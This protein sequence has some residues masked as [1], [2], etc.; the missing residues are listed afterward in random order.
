MQ[1]MDFER[2]FSTN[3]VQSLFGSHLAFSNTF[4]ET[5]IN[6]LSIV[7]SLHYIKKYL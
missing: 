1:C 7:F 3:R 4:I 2:L 6:G 5:V